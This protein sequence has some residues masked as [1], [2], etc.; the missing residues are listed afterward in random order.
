ML[1]FPV[2][3]LDYKLK[4]QIRSGARNGE[5]LGSYTVHFVIRS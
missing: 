1:G 3:I 2:Y 5:H 4:W